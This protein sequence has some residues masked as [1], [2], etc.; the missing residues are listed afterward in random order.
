MNSHKYQSPSG[1]K[2]EDVRQS[3]GENKTPT[4]WRICTLYGPAPDTL[5]IITLRPHPEKLRIGP[6]RDRA[7]LTTGTAPGH[8][9][10]PT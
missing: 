5:T 4:A 2:G 3:N 1:P 10:A 6:Y 9:V 7:R 8:G